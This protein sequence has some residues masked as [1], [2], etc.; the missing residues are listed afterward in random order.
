MKVRV[1]LQDLR[2]A[3]RA[4]R[5]FIDQRVR[6]TKRGRR[7]L[8][9]AGR[10]MRA[11][12]GIPAK[13][14]MGNVTVPA[15][16]LLSFL[17]TAREQELIL[18]VDSEEPEL[19]IAGDFRVVLAGGAERE[20]PRL[21]MGD[22][23]VSVTLPGTVFAHGVNTVCAHAHPE[24]PTLNTVRVQGGYGQTVF[25][26]STGRRL[27]RLVTDTEVPACD[28]LIPVSAAMYMESCDDVHIAQSENWLRLTNAERKI[29][30]PRV[31]AQFPAWDVPAPHTVM[32]IS[33]ADWQ[34][35]TL[36]IVQISSGSNGILRLEIGASRVKVCAEY[37]WGM[38]EA[39]CP[40]DI[41]GPTFDWTC[42]GANLAA[43]VQDGDIRL[44]L[45]PGAPALIEQGKYACLVAPLDTV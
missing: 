42:N 26:A 41:E 16:P 24:I 35:Y 31:Q 12:C 37:E 36:P 33:M 23:G 15:E 17:N 32:S 13:G 9:E 14:S 6:L 11:V 30:T 29:Y 39:S 7:L 44:S 38:G 1:S 34:K 8:V 4:V 20:L 43:A 19:K 22:F 28:F 10:E 27:A 5:P 3:I 40:A 2:R 25:S 21:D 18:R 45:A